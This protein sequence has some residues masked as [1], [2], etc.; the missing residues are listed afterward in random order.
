[1]R[2]GT[3]G[4]C[5]EIARLDDGTIGIRDSKDPEG[6]TLRI[7]TDEWLAFLE[8]VARQEFDNR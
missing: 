6:P 1:M 7:G 8:G 4:N 5:V 3:N 2:S